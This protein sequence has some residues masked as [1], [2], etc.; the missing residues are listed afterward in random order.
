MGSRGRVMIFDSGARPRVLPLAWRAGSLIDGARSY[1]VRSWGEAYAQL[2]AHRVSHGPIREIQVW[3]HGYPGRPMIGPDGP[4]LDA[5][6]SAAGDQLSLIWWRSCDVHRSHRFARDASRI[7]GATSVGHC[8]VISAPIPWQ[9]RAICALRPGEDPWWDPSGEG[10]RA[11]SALRMR[12]P[13]FA[14]RP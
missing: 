4:D 12:V 13:D 1:G 8:A 2:Q 14:Y 11:C 9:Q 5:L 3:S 6:R 7:L 10:L